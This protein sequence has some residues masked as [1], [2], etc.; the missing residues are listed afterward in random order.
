MK[1]NLSTEHLTVTSVDQE[2]IDKKLLKLEKLVHE[3][4]TMDIR[5]VHDTHHRH[6]QVV[7]CTVNIAQGKRVFHAERE[8]ESIQ[9][10]LD[11]VITALRHE[12]Q[13]A[14]KK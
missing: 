14:Y 4:Y 7:T 5:L 9:T 11:E 2:L 6:G 8:S 10:S 13:K 3:P 1:Y 12:L